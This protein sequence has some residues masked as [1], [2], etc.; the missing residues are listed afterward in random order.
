MGDLKIGLVVP[1]SGCD[2]KCD[3]AECHRHRRERQGLSAVKQKLD[4]CEED[5]W[6]EIIGEDV[7]P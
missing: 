1:A 6:T 3:C 5:G 2:C 4:I 7:K